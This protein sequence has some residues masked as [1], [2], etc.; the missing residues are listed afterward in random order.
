LKGIGERRA[1][2]KEKYMGDGKEGPWSATGKLDAAELT[3]W[4]PSILIA[5]DIVQ[6][7]SSGE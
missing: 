7:D 6:R 5:A 3:Y 1:K 4:K 2:V